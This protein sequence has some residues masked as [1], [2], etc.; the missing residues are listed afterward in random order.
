MDTQHIVII[1][2]LFIFADIVFY[3]VIMKGLLYT[4]IMGP[5]PAEQARAAKEP[6]FALELY[7]HCPLVDEPPRLRHNSANSPSNLAEEQFFDFTSIVRQELQN[8]RLDNIRFTP[9][10]DLRLG[11]PRRVDMILTQDIVGS[12][13]RALNDALPAKITTLKIGALLKASLSGDHFVVVTSDP[14]EQRLTTGSTLA[15]AWEVTPLKSGFKA[16]GFELELNIK[17]AD[18]DE[19]RL[20]T[21]REGEVRVE[22]N[23]LFVIKNFLKRYWAWVLLNALV[24]TSVGYVVWS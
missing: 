18:S 6:T 8:L 4:S 23:A 14:E 17:T 9:P 12:V 5:T 3:M 7:H 21:W 15:W 11:V 20:Y 24:L 16:M 22:G 1:I 2:V 19:K 13:T 10:Y